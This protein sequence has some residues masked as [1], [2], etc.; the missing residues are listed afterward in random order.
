M[1]KMN[2]NLNEIKFKTM[3]KKGTKIKKI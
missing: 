3:T 1:N 2:S